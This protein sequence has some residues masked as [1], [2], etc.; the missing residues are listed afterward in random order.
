MSS[1]MVAQLLGK[2]R[3]DLLPWLSSCIWPHQHLTCAALLVHSL[4]EHLL[5]AYLWF[6][7]GSV[8]GVL[9]DYLHPVLWCFKAI[10]VSWSMRNWEKWDCRGSLTAK[11]TD[12]ALGWRSSGTATV[13]DLLLY[14]NMQFQKLCCT[15]KGDTWVSPVIAIH[16]ST[17]FD[18]I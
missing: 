18:F 10:S 7:H 11:S 6:P 1:E 16:G 8:A 13:L 2:F 15:S 5:A 12:K 14:I 9:S 3:S 4:E 17:L